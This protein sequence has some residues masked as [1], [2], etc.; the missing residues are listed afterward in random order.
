MSSETQTS[1]ADTACEQEAT[2]GTQIMATSPKGGIQ[3]PGL[4]AHKAKPA[5]KDDKPVQKPAV[6]TRPRDTSEDLPQAGPTLSCV[7]KLRVKGPAGRTLQ[8]L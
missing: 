1:M 7:T 8:P 2:T 4:S 5:V 6:V 3:L